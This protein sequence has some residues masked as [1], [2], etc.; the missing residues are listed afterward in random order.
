MDQPNVEMLQ[1][2]LREYEVKN[3]QLQQTLT[4]E[5]QKYLSEI[6][7]LKQDRITTYQQETDHLRRQISE[8]EYKY[9]QLHQQYEQ[10]VS[11]YRSEILSIQ[12]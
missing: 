12:N 6:E 1:Q 2:Q 10:D 9:K 5:A 3:Q 11:R 7:R 8:Y 4:I